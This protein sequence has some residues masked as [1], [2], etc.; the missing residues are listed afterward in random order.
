MT[1]QRRSPG[2]Q[3]RA[4]LA[5][6]RVT[7]EDAEARVEHLREQRN[8]LILSG[9]EQGLTEREAA[10]AGGVSPTYAHRIRRDAGRPLSGPLD[11]RRYS[12][13]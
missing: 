8:L 2:D 4:E 5:A 12:S 3:W 10:K 11:A 1:R 6:I 9:M 7:L 13:E